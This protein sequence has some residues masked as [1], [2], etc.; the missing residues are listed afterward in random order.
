MGATGLK[1]YTGYLKNGSYAQNGAVV[2]SPSAGSSS[3]GTSASSGS[4]AQGL[5]SYTSNNLASSIAGIIGT[6]ASSYGDYIRQALDYAES[7]TATSQAFAREQMD[8]QTQSNQTAMA[9]SAQEAQ[10]NRDWQTEMS[11]T[12]HQREVE[13]LIKAGIN[14]ILSANG[15][16][17]TGSGATG[18]AFSSSGAQGSVDTSASGVLSGLVNNIISSATNMRIAQLYNETNKYNTDMNYAATQLQADA[19]ILNSYRTS[20]ATKYAA[21]TNAGALLRN[22]ELNYQAS[23]NSAASSKEAS[24]Y[25]TD[26]DLEAR[27]YASDQAYKSAVDAAHASNLKSPFGIASESGLGIFNGISKMSGIPFTDNVQSY[28][29]NYNR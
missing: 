6:D 24:I 29:E 12:A 1:G 22:G 17:Y 2:S 3:G 8:Y 4:V 9:W 5:N 27:K 21:A 11:N 16:A 20:E 10:K 23:L 7:N 14:P 13:D 18:Q 26:K 15:G 19:S 28:Y 25:G